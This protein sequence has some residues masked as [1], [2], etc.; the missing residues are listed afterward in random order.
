M[1][2]FVGADAAGTA[3]TWVA[4]IVTLGV[5]SY[6]VGGGRIFRLAQYLLAGLAT[7]YLVVLAVREVLVPWLLDPLVAD[8][9]GEPLLWVGLLL[10]AAL[11]AGRWLPPVVPAVPVALLVAAT[12]AFALGGAVVGT[13]LPQLGASVLVPGGGPG[14]LLNAAIGAVITVLVLLAFLHGTRRGRIS[15]AA[16]GIGR[17]LMLAG[18]GGWLGFLLVSRLTVLLERIGFL[19]GDWLGIR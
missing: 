9:A 4:A 12:A 17:W 14:D 2:G 7:G 19:L 10:A 6:A 13:L 18:L 16:M 15:G 3:A 8:P 1:N 5:W 11:V